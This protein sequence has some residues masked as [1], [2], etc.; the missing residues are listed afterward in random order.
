MN[1]YQQANE[2]IRLN[3]DQK[4]AI[5]NEIMS[6]ETTPAKKTL[7]GFY[8]WAGIVAG[9]FAVVL[10]LLLPGRMSMSGSSNSTM[11]ETM[12]MEEAADTDQAMSIDSETVTE[13]A[14]EPA[15]GAYDADSLANDLQCRVPD[16]SSY[17]GARTVEYSRTSETTGTVYVTTEQGEFVLQIEALSET[18]EA[19][20]EYSITEFADERAYEVLY[21]DEHV[22]YSLLSKDSL[23]ETEREELKGFLSE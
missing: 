7:P 15:T 3:E 2:Q 5:L 21:E 9:A 17:P 23:S 8:R 10:L 4:E 14:M 16:F 13:G 12:A 1:K 11:N 22:R 6:M 18:S 19:K 20:Q